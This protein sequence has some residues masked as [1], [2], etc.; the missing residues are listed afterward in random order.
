[1]KKQVFKVQNESVT[2]VFT[3][4]CAEATSLDIQLWI[5]Q[6]KLILDKK[7]GIRAQDF[8]IRSAFVTYYFIKKH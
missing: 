2:E 3:S 8:Y 7:G 4:G 6:N 5:E 1:M